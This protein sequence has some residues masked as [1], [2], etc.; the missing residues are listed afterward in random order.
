MVEIALTARKK[1]NSIVIEGDKSKVTLPVQP[2]NGPEHRFNFTLND[3][4]NLGVQFSSLDTQDN[5]SNC[6]PAQGKNS[7]LIHGDHIDKGG[8]SAHFTDSN[9]NPAHNGSVDVC[10][11]WNFVCTGPSKLDV[12]PFDPIIQNDGRT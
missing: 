2:G 10:Y 5:C 1:G 7:N 12:E 6:P 9:M 8:L 3:P 4:D 11:Q